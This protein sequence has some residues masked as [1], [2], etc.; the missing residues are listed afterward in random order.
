MA[1][2]TPYTGSCGSGT[3]CGGLQVLPP[4]G[5]PL[6]IFLEKFEGK[7]DGAVV[8]LNWNTKMEIS[9]KEFILQSGSGNSFTDVATI[10][11]KNSEAGSRYSYNDVSLTSSTI[12]Y[13]LKMVDVD[14]TFKYSPVISV[15]GNSKQQNV[16]VYPNPSRGDIRVQLN[17][18][19][20]V[21]KLDILDMSGRVVNS[22]KVGSNKNIQVGGLKS[23]MYL[24][25]ARDLK[26]GAITTQKFSVIK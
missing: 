16:V 22:I 21:E 12:Q 5:G 24:I 7:R 2:F 17:A 23:G 10:P 18:E 20:K 19:S 8:S 11:A 9:A 15:D 25:H 26:T 6:P 3:Q 1:T 13:R 4:A 14:G